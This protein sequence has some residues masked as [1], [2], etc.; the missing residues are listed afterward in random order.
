[1]NTMQS[2]QN[3]RKNKDEYSGQF[4]KLSIISNASN[5]LY[6]SVKQ[7]VVSKID[8]KNG[9]ILSKLAPSSSNFKHI[10]S[11]LMNQNIAKNLID[12]KKSESN[13]S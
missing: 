12:N 3:Q 2:L 10:N 5:N 8:L 1:M 6:K 11:Y 13:A 7:E 9:S 4:E